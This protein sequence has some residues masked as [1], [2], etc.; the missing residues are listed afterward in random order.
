VSLSNLHD[1]HGKENDRHDY[2]RYK[3]NIKGSILLLCDVP[4]YAVIVQDDYVS[5]IRRLHS[6]R[7]VMLEQE[8]VKDNKHRA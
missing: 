6:L 8:N 3:R 1:D 4:V 2:G 7:K 5:H